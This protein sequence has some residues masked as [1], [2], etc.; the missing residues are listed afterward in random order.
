MTKCVSYLSKWNLSKVA[1][2]TVQEVPKLG[3]DSAKVLNTLFKTRQ[4]EVSALQIFLS[5]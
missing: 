1:A 3:V 5:K 2:I 4:Q